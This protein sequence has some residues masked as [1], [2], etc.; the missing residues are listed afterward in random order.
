MTMRIR[1][2]L[3]S[4]AIVCW[5]PASGECQW[6]LDGFTRGAGNTDVALSY[7]RER[8]D[9][10]FL[11]T[12]NIDSPAP[13]GTLTSVSYSLFVAYGLN[14]SMD[15]VASVPY[16]SAKGSGVGGPPNQSGLQD[17]SLYW[18]WRP[19]NRSLGSSSLSLLTGLGVQAPLSNYV[20]DSP[21]AIGH[22]STNVEALLL[23]HWVHRAGFFIDGGTGYTGRSGA[24]PDSVPYIAKAGYFNGRVYL[25]VFVDRQD[26]QGG[27]DIGQGSF[28]ATA[29]DY[30]RVGGTLF[31]PV[32]PLF[33]LFAGGSN[34]VDGRNVKNSITYRSGVVL[35]F[36]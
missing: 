22:H 33:G 9:Q 20:A 26:A 8:A 24:V 15:L 17:A 1:G 2:A 10:F 30:T 12:A 23:L 14:D 16:M 32:S 4:V 29:V 5:L 27:I 35:R 18:K 25:D 28:A 19:W 21:I 13:L 31:V 3:L 36:H 34:I 6:I 11:G 7:S